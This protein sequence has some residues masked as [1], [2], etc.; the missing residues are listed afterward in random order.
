MDKIFQPSRDVQDPVT[1]ILP[2]VGRLMKMSTATCANVFDELEMALLLLDAGR[3]DLN[4]V[5]RELASRFASTC[6]IFARDM[7][8]AEGNLNAL[9]MAFGLPLHQ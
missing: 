3:P 6:K 9:R 4:P 7:L 8:A 1:T 2:S 5:Q